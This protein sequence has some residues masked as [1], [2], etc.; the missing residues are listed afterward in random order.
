MNSL[1]Y[2][3]TC[4]ENKGLKAN[5][6]FAFSH[7]NSGKKLRYECHNNHL[8][9]KASQQYVVKCFND[10]DL[11]LA[12]KLDTRCVNTKNLFSILKKNVNVVDNSV[13]VVKKHIEFAWNETENVY[14]FNKTGIDEF[15]N[16]YV[17][18]ND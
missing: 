11:Y 9:R 10:Q 16:I 12:W 7:S 13:C 18:D 8:S 17:I 15:L 2:F 1:E 6:I 5:S 14:C 3:I 4:C